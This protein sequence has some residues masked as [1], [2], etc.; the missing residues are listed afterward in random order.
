MSMITLPKGLT[1]IGDEAFSGCEGFRDQ[2]CVV[3][4]GVE[5]IGRCAFLDTYLDELRTAEPEF[6]EVGHGEQ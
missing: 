1:E 5:R 4:A 3:P 6:V 2:V